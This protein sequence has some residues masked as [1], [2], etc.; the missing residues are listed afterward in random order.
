MLLTRHF[1]KLLK[2]STMNKDVHWSGYRVF[3]TKFYK[4]RVKN[5]QLK[6]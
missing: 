3:S 6:E 1:S 4:I 2:W 5:S